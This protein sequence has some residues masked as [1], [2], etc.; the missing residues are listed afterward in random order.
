MLSHRRCKHSDARLYIRVLYHRATDLFRSLRK[1]AVR[2]NFFLARSTI[3]EFLPSF[4]AFFIASYFRLFGE[5]DNSYKSA[6]KGR[7]M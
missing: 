2:T 3:D 4:P 6:E 7:S 5:R 1:I